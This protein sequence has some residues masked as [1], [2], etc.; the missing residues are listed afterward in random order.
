MC[1][2]CKYPRELNVGDVVSTLGSDYEILKTHIDRADDDPERQWYRT[3]LLTGPNAGYISD[4]PCN[5]LCHTSPEGN[6]RIYA[7]PGMCVCGK[8]VR[9]S[10]PE[11]TSMHGAWECPECGTE[12]PFMFYEIK[13]DTD[14][15]PDN[16]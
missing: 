4:N 11:N 1:K 10:Y 13:Q 15:D 2:A 5:M 6:K 14:Y 7:K 3:K 9:L 12:Y 16:E 8:V